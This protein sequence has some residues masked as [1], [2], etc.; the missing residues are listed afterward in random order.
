MKKGPF[1][2]AGLFRFGVCLATIDLERKVAFQ[3]GRS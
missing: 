1:G 3:V 2:V